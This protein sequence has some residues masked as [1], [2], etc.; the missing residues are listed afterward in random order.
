MTA[1]P[2]PGPATSPPGRGTADLLDFL[3]FARRAG[4][5]TQPTAASYRLG[6]RRILSALPKNAT[7][8]LTALNPDHAVAVFAASDDA[9]VTEATRRQYESSFRKAHF[10]YLSYLADPARWHA[11]AG[12]NPAAPGWSTAEDGGQELTIPL[13]RHRT[14]RLHLPA[15]VTANDTRL[16]KRLISS[17]LNELPAVRDGQG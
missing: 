13:P 10:L 12:Q 5:I 15:D 17:Y 11:A 7:A 3:D 14:M 6:A 2:L 9:D 4:L 8:D 1:T 16:A